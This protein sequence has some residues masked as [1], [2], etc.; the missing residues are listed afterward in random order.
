MECRPIVIVGSGPAGVATALFLQRLDAELAA[1]AVVL[2][3]AAHPRDK[4]CAG[5]VIPHTLECLRELEIELSVPAVAVHRARV[6]IPGRTVDYAGRN[7]C[8]VIRRREFDASLARVCRERGIEIREREKVVRV[9]R[10]GDR[11]RVDTERQTYLARAIVGA[12]GSGSIVHR[13]LFAGDRAWLGR[14][15]MADI[16]VAETNWDGFDRARYE[17]D[18]RAVPAGLRGYTWAFPCLI[19]G[20]PHANI[21]VYSEVPAGGILSQLLAAKAAELGA[22]LRDRKAFPIRGYHRR[23]PLA[24]PRVLLVGDAAGADPL[25]GEGISHA[26][27]YGRRAAGCLAWAFRTGDFEFADYAAAVRRSWFGTKLHRLRFATRLFYGP[28]WRLWFALAAR[29]SRAQDIG[30]RWYNGVDGWDRASVWAALRAVL[31]DRRMDRSAA[32][33]FRE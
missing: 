5:G 32:G 8:H 20:I 22:Q 4:V 26:F 28:T 25:L 29:S 23:A 13:Q 10:E 21:G 2:E 1:E 11:I 9:A 6:R 12:D 17:F 33:E 16:P 24:A 30:I 7:L 31:G 3:K 27:E 15:V 14:A 18:F 19:D